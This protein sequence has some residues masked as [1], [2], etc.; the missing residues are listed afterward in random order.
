MKS[1]RDGLRRGRLPSGWRRQSQGQCAADI[2]AIAAQM[3]VVQL[4]GFSLNR[5]PRPSFERTE[6]SC[7]SSKPWQQRQ[8]LP[9]LRRIDFNHARQSRITVERFRA[10]LKLTRPP[11]PSFATESSSPA[12]GIPGSE[13]RDLHRSAVRRASRR[14]AL[15]HRC[16]RQNSCHQT[17]PRTRA[18][19]AASGAAK[20]TAMCKGALAQSFSPH[21]GSQQIVSASVQPRLRR[22]A[23]VRPPRPARQASPSPRA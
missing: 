5:E 7:K 9:T 21:L 14:V 16:H 2:T 23:P 4:Q 10:P 13:R 18:A 3:D 1:T 19:V 8:H 22:R 20:S 12:L 15:A 6:L 17:H 11:A